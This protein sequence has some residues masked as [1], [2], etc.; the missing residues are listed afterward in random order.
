MP[1]LYY[2]RYLNCLIMDNSHYSDSILVLFRYV[3][4]KEFTTL[5]NKVI[6]RSVELGIVHLTT[7]D[8][9]LDGR[10]VTM[11]GQEY[12]NFGSCNYL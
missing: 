1:V 4:K 8:E 5:I 6:N 2:L 7:Q 9:F 3:M 10:V 11:N 12:I